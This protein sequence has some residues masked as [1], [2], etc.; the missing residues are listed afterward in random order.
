MKQSQINFLRT[1]GCTIEQMKAQYQRGIN[2]LVEMENRARKSGRTY[3]GY[4]ALD[5]H[6]MVVKQRAALAALDQ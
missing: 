2:T 5:L 3:N 1:M 6:D 4:T